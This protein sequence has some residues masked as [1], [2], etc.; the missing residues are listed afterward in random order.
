[1]GISRLGENQELT[2]HAT[3]V[4]PGFGDLRLSSAGEMANSVSLAP[5]IT[6]Q[7]RPSGQLQATDV[8]FQIPLEHREDVAKVEAMK[9]LTD[10]GAPGYL[11]KGSSVIL[12]KVDGSPGATVSIEE[13][14]VH[15]TT[16]PATDTNATGDGALLSFVV[17]VFN[18][19]LLPGS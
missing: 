12:E 13:A 19:R 2:R 6:G 8:T 4:T 16:Y 17:N 10:A 15:T 5:M 14:F 9:A 7:Q 18:A 1:M 3:W 11:Q